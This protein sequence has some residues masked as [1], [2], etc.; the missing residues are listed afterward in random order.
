MRKQLKFVGF[1]KWLENEINLHLKEYGDES[2]IHPHEIVGCMYGQLSKLS[3]AADKCIYS[4]YNLPNFVERCRKL[5][6]A[7]VIAY[8]SSRCFGGEVVFVEDED[9]VV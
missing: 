6:M 1:C 5:L 7:A 9:S 2:F 8:E 4:T 3:E